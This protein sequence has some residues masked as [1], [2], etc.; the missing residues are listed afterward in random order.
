MARDAL[1]CAVEGARRSGV[2]AVGLTVLLGS[3]ALAQQVPS[4]ED[5]ERKFVLKGIVVEGSTV[6]RQ[7]G[8]LS[9]WFASST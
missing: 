2:F 5:A 3:S 8:F 4:P 9:P 1:G 7:P 6:Y